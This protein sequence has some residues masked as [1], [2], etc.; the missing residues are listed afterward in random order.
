MICGYVWPQDE[1]LQYEGWVKPENMWWSFPCIH[2]PNH[3]ARECAEWFDSEAKNNPKYA[4]YIKK[5]KYDDFFFLEF[6]KARYPSRTVLNLNPCLVD[7]VDFL[8]GGSVINRE[9]KHAPVRATW[10]EDL[11]LVDELANKIRGRL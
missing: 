11:D 5:K 2:I 8:L 7:H 6:L 1:N 10:F 9:R 4:S 3:M